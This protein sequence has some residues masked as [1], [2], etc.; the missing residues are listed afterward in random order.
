M[1]Q[2]VLSCTL[3]IFAVGKNRLCYR[4]SCRVGWRLAP[5]QQRCVASISGINNNAYR[6][7]RT[8]DEAVMAEGVIVSDDSRAVF[9]F[10][11]GVLQ[12]HCGWSYSSRKNG[13]NSGCDFTTAQQT[14]QRR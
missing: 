1:A 12:N 8:K 9:L 3:S 6:V 5:P 11:I 7:P 4:E 10:F 14:W 2:S 13:S